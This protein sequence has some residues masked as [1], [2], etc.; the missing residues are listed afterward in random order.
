MSAGAMEFLISPTSNRRI[1][2]EASEP[3]ME[4]TAPSELEFRQDL[5]VKTINCTQ[6]RVSV[7][8]SDLK[9]QTAMAEIHDLIATRGKTDEVIA[10]VA[11]RLKF[12]AF[13]L[14]QFHP[15]PENDAAWGKGFTEW[16]N[17]TKAP[18]L[19]K[20]HYQPHL[21]TELGF[22]DLRL[23]EVQHQQIDYAKAH[24]I[25][26]FCF[27]YYWFAGKRVLQRPI[28]DFLA[29]PAADIQFCLCWANENWTRRWDGQDHE[30][31]I[32]QTYSEA[33][34]ISFIENLLPY[35]RD[36]RYLR[37][38]NA[39]VLLIYYPQK[40]PDAPSTTARWREVCRREGIGEIHIVA[41]LTH[42]NWEYEGMGFDAGMEFPPH[43][44][45]ATDYKH[46][47]DLLRPVEGTISW[48]GDIAE[49]YLAH[50]YRERLVYRGVFPSWDNT[51][52]VQG[53]GTIVLDGTPENYAL[54]LHRATALTLRERHPSQQL[55]FINAW[56]E[57]A[58]GCHLEPDRKYGLNFLE[59]TRR[60]KQG[61]V[62][63]QTSFSAVELP[64]LVEISSDE[65]SI[66]EKE[67][68]LKGILIP[69]APSPLA[70]ITASV[71]RE[72]PAA[73]EGESLAPA[74]IGL[75]P[76]TMVILPQSPVSIRLVERICEALA[77]YP[78]AFRSMRG[79]YRLILKSN[80]HRF[81]DRLTG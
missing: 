79:I 34:D 53:R 76:A 1:S 26:A 62:P 32:L 44:P 13:Y 75:E 55:V 80:L 22:Y 46:R 65:P 40:L 8:D 58:E 69:P 16:V 6:T 56:N 35:F 2:L 54:W 4:L 3:R 7:C 49:H 48:F 31:L 27:H 9:Q 50:D 20:G 29:D 67:E 78:L 72:T 11:N 57:W 24:G 45:K 28:E 12:I 17:V 25:D 19:F 23:R 10:E 37:V 70:A 63:A 47:L 66:P 30:I 52:R 74:K 68:L 36:P 61:E 73:D 64:T 18:Q 81:C 51:A 14:P 5:V 33:H 39:P 60:V 41:A 38:N 71:L 15:I 21:P 77:G 59:A 42:G 43:D